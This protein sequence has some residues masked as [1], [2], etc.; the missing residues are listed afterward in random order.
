MTFWSLDT[1]RSVPYS[2]LN[3]AC[4]YASSFKLSSNSAKLTLPFIYRYSLCI[5][6]LYSSSVN[7]ITLSTILHSEYFPLKL[8]LGYLLGYS[9]SY[10]GW[11]WFTHD[12]LKGL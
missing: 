11:L 5:T 10:P 2:L 8:H 4:Q 12:A 1:I 6:E 3:Y 7:S 9:S